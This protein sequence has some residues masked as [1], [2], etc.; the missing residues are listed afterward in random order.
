[1]TIPTYRLLD[2]YSGAGGASVGYA[3]AGFKVVGVDVR[4]QPRYPFEFIQADAL[5]YLAAHGHEF[6]AIHASPPCQGHSSMK[7]LPRNKASRAVHEAADAI[8]DLRTSL[9]K[10]SEATGAPWII[11]NTPLA[12]LTNAV[13][14][15]GTQFGLKVYRHR[16]FES[17]IVLFG[18]P[19]APHKDAWGSSGLKT[20]ESRN[21]F[22]MVCG[23]MSREKFRK[24][25]TAM[26][27]DWMT[28]AELV[29]A[30]PPAYTEFLG[31]QLI[32][33]LNNR[34]STNAA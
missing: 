26:G 15:C 2:L 3:R 6:D 28:R 19:H 5:E 4:K 9:R 34:C 7:F 30:I 1:M 18:L 29:N 14:L 23:A 13:V 21:G 22:M 17:N 16:V 32:N 25:A 10:I 8:P 20:R 12:P 11:E 27:I 33:A 31:R 24:C